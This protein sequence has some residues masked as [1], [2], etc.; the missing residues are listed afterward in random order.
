MP[1]PHDEGTAQ[2]G[3]EEGWA[4]RAGEGGEKRQ[5][6]A[7]TWTPWATRGRGNAEAGAGVLVGGSS[8]PEV[9]EQR[10]SSL[11]D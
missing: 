8:R 11:R 4:K 10:D 6:Q 7:R 5:G 9:E 3:L 2:G 1:P